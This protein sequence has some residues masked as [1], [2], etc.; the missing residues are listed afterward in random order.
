MGVAFPLVN[1]SFGVWTFVPF[2]V[3]LLATVIF[4][5]WYVPETRGKSLEVLL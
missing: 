4:T 5:H 2:A 1:S 3:V